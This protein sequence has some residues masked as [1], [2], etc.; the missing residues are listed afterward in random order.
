MDKWLERASVFLLVIFGLLYIAAKIH[1]FTR[2]A[3]LG[4]GKYV[5]E[6]WPL[7]AGFAIIGG[8]WVCFDWIRKRR[9]RPKSD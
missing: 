3:V 8:I 1:F 5:D 9:G 2:Y 4:P 7:W 6:H